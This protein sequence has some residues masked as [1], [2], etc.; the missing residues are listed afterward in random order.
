MDI[1][2]IL[3]E[4]LEI[5]KTLKVPQKKAQ[6]AARRSG[7][8]VKSTLRSFF[9]ED[10]RFV[11]IGLSVLLAVFAAFSLCVFY[12]MRNY[13]QVLLYYTGKNISMAKD[14]LSTRRYLLYLLTLPPLAAVI[15][16]VFTNEVEFSLGEVIKDLTQN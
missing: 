12:H 15:Y 6:K 10:Y 13:D 11:V 1:S 7:W 16:Y 8:T 5:V 3:K 14:I 4:L 2:E 9:Y